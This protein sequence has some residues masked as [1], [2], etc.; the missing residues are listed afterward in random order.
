MERSLRSLLQ[1]ALQLV[2]LQLQL[3]NLDLSELWGRAKIAA[4]LCIMASVAMVAALPVLLLSFAEELRAVTNWSSAGALAV[5]SGT[6]LALGAAALFWSLRQLTHAGASLARSQQEL[7][8][9]MAWLRSMLSGDED[10]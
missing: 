5:V 1:D 6:T 2:D 4:A 10:E 8:E 3:F 7:K 9:N